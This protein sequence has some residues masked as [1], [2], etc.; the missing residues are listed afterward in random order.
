MT[1][2]SSLL[3]S[4]LEVFFFSV[5]VGCGAVVTALPADV[6]AGAPPVAPAVPPPVGGVTGV[7]SE[8][9]SEPTGVRIVLSDWIETGFNSRFTMTLVL[10]EG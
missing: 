1:S 9:L 4:G 8:P 6:A 7:T 2:V 10:S 3:P 5:E